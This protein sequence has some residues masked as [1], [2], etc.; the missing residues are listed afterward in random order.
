MKI[1]HPVL[2]GAMLTACATSY[3]SNG[4]MGGYSEKQLKENVFEVKFGGNGLTTRQRATDFALLRSAELTLEKGYNYF[5]IIDSQRVL[6]VTKESVDMSRTG[7]TPTTYHVRQP[8]AVNTIVCFKNKPDGESY[9]AR[10]V[11][12]SLKQKYDL[13]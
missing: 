3:Q 11:V 5:V 8:T 13:D 1:F 2:L 7:T 10:A 6:R 4:L 9:D 12:Q